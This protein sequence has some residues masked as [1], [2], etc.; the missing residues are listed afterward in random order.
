MKRN[1]WLLFLVGLLLMPVPVES[2]S[3][4]KSAKQHAAKTHPPAATE[5][6][7]AYEA[8]AVVDAATGE[9]LEGSNMQRTWPQASLTKL[10]L[11]CVVMD[12]VERGQLRLADPV[13]I[14]AAAA[15]MGGSQLYLKAGETFS[16]EDLMKAALI[17]SANDAAFAVAEHASGSAEAFVALMNDKAKALGMTDTEYFCVHGLPPAKGGSENI[18]TCV[19]MIRLAQEALKRPEIIDWTSTEQTTLRNGMLTIT[20][21]NKLLGKLPEVDGLKTGYY[22]K[23]GFNI[24]ATGKNDS[25]RLIVVILGSPQSRVRDQ[26]AVEKFKEYLT[27]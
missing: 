19:D 13:T 2:G 23:A 27:N 1:V 25:R 11:A 18:T 6:Q 15:R 4:R 8:Y 12:K 9:L 24:V 21:R 7:A 22:R 26:F 14:S 16:L 20:N 17:E 3:V 10:M 5:P